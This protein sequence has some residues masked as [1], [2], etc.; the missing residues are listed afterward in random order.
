M[1][2]D[3]GTTLSYGA[4]QGRE[5]NSDV[6]FLHTFQGCECFLQKPPDSGAISVIGDKPAFKGSHTFTLRIDVGK[7]PIIIWCSMIENLLCWQINLSICFSAYPMM[8]SGAQKLHLRPKPQHSS[9]PRLLAWCSANEISLKWRSLNFYVCHV[10]GK[11]VNLD[12]GKKNVMKWCGSWMNMSLC[13]KVRD[14]KKRLSS[15]YKECKIEK[16]LCEG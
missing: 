9:S 8:S 4:V 6:P 13:D 15:G 3:Q 16:H 5:K 12:L 10:S 7:Y 1:C 11:I 14:K 2:Q